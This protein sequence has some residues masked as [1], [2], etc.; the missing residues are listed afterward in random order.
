MQRST[1]MAKVT[2]LAAIVVVGLAACGGTSG[3]SSSSGKSS[4][5]ASV[6]QT[7]RATGFTSTMFVNAVGLTHQAGTATRAVIG[8]DDMAYLGGHIFVGFQN[9]VGSM[10]EASPLG[11]DSTIV[12][13]DL[14]GHKI[15]Q[16]DVVGK[17][18][19]LGA[20]PAT[21]RLIATVN[22]DG[23]S[24]VY[25]I[26]PTGGSAPVH[27]D[28][29]GKLPHGGGTDSIAAHN[30]TVLIT[31][32]APDSKVKSAPAVY[33]VTFDSANHVAAFHEVFTDVAKASVA[34]TN[35]STSGKTR[36]LALTDPDSS[37]IVPAFATRFAGDYV[38]DSQGDKEQIFAH[39]AGASNQ[40][41]SVLKLSASVDDAAWVADPSGA[42]YTTDNVG[43]AIHKITGPFV[44]GSEL[45]A[46]TPCNDNNAPSTCPGPGYPQNYLGQLN[47]QT[48]AITPIPVH[49]AATAPKGMLFIP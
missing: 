18:D 23:H 3:K 29:S 14:Q 31:A 22:E 47:P 46:V 6:A 45:V 38:L 10:G 12:E 40:S 19:G 21:N 35:Q 8:P 41:L 43:D 2:L 11:K 32:S 27:Y 49:G 17:N 7:G 33:R 16:W 39:N 5:T 4:K 30:G 15:A 42:I 44:K 28:Y 36:Q 48:G 25:L 26:N 13:F 9:G 24:S 20:D 1:R 37:A 34:N